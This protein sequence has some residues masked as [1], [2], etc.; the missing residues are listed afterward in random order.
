LTAIFGFGAHNYNSYFFCVKNSLM[1][2]LQIVRI[3][4]AFAERKIRSDKYARKLKDRHGFDK[5][6]TSIY[7]Q[8]EFVRNKLSNR[9]RNEEQQA[10]VV[11]IDMDVNARSE[12]K[13]NSVFFVLLFIFYWYGKTCIFA[14]L[15]L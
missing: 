5:A 15:F 14:S 2:I 4:A 6:P 8:D 3:R 9:F 10:R 1:V 7:G 13:R 12:S 11:K